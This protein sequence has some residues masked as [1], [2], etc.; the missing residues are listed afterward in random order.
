MTNLVLFGSPG[1]G[2]GTQAKRLEAK[3]GLIQIST[4]DVFRYNIKNETPLGQKAKAYIDKG[5]LVP[6]DVTINML[7]SEVEKDQDGKGF[8][9][10]GFPRT[11]A[12]AEALDELMESKNTQVDAMI[13]LDVDDEILVERLLKRGKTSGRKDDANES[14]IRDRIKVYYE[15][16]DI[17]K[18]YYKK[19][20]KYHEIDGEG[21]IED[22]SKRINK[23]VDKLV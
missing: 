13:A 23:V 2:K 4:G 3:Y 9:F 14:I 12:Q 11:K 16:T 15:K 10:D 21:E 17:V 8:I 7:K 22:I 1:A 5:E 19:V 6:D 20:G 18:S